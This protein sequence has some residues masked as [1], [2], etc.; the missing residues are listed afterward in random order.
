M[1]VIKTYFRH[2]VCKDGYK[3]DKI[4]LPKKTGPKS[5]ELKNFKEKDLHEALIEFINISQ[6]I[7]KGADSEETIL[8]FINKYGLLMD[9]SL[10]K[11]FINAHKKVPAWARGGGYFDIDV[12]YQKSDWCRQVFN[13]H[14]KNRKKSARDKF[15]ERWG[16]D[17]ALM[18]DIEGESIRPLLMPLNLDEAMHWTLGLALSDIRPIRVCP[19]CG[20]YFQRRPNSLQCGN[21]C[22]NK[23]SYYKRKKK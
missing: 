2:Q 21:D 10:D 5:Y 18:K 7:D 20:K 14:R 12:Y 9:L 16:Y 4:F 22:K 23:K 17:I 6:L 11:G 13:L 8:S 3:L 15:N 1:T 19:V